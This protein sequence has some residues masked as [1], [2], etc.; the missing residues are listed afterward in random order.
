MRKPGRRPLGLSRYE[1]GLT[2]VFTAAYGVFA[3]VIVG[4]WIVG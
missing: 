4:G 1:H 2:W 3:A